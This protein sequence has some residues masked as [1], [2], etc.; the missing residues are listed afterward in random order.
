MLREPA[1]LQAVGG[2]SF[3]IEAGRTLAVVGESGCGKSTL[4]RVVA[5]IEKPSAGE[6]A[7]R[8]HRCGA[9]PTPREQRALRKTV[10]MVFQNPVRLAQSAQEDRRDP[11]GAARDQHRPRAAAARRARARD[12]RQGR[13]APRA[14]RPLPAHVLRRPAPAHRDRARADA[15][16]RAGGRRR[17]GLGARRLG[18]GAGAE[19]AGRPAARPR[20]SPT[21]SSRTI[22]AVVRHIAHDVLVMYLGLAMEQGPKER[23]FARPLHPYTQ[24][25]L[26]STPGLGGDAQAAHRAEGRVAVAAR[27]RRRGAC[28]PPAARTRSTAA[29]P[30]ARSLRPLDGRQ[31]ACHLAEQFLESGHTDRIPVSLQSQP[32]HVGGV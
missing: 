31:V 19:P 27:T 23:I 29:A 10:Q 1:H 11:R 3:A 17:A 15:R 16:A 4:A 6:L 28:S 32:I 18:A 9:T 21:S 2:V 14:L 8:R 7:A 13:L 24:A 25:L 5:L 30:S 22:S 12:A 26:A 20:A